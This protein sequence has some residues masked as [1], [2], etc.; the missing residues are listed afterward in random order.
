MT[1][2]QIKNKIDQDVTNK[3][4]KKSI[5]PSIVGALL[6]AM[7]DFCISFFIPG[8]LKGAVNG[9]AELDA[10]GKVPADQLPDDIG[11]GGGDFDLVAG[12]NAQD[13]AELDE[14]MADEFF[15][16]TAGKVGISDFIEMLESLI[17]GDGGLPSNNYLEMVNQ[18]Q[19]WDAHILIRDKT[20][21]N[22]RLG[23]KRSCEFQSVSSGALVIGD[24]YMI[25]AYETG[26]DFTN[27]A[28]DVRGTGAINTNGC[29]FTATGTTPTDFSNGTLLK[30][31]IGDFFVSPVANGFPAETLGHQNWLLTVDNDGNMNRTENEILIE[32]GSFDF[33][34][35]NA[36]SATTYVGI[37]LPDHGVP[38][39]YRVLGVI[40]DITDAF[41]SATSVNTLAFGLSGIST[42]FANA[43]TLTSQRKL[44]VVPPEQDIQA[45]ETTTTLDLNFGGGVANPQ[46]FTA[47][48]VTISAIVKKVY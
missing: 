42:I 34:D 1:E 12:I 19:G 41:V 29:I 4:A 37:G 38:A 5:T 18:E 22:I 30:R 15:P 26:D 43:I 6:K 3:I 27:I 31:K 24:D 46:D 21:G 25:D 40:I 45:F 44:L 17:G 23:M 35:L 36:A 33:A 7:I 32:L 28:G 47:G 11:G 20:T 16:T 39:N 9:I 48:E 13:E 2:E 14:G 10:D 8:T